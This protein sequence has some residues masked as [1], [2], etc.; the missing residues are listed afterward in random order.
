LASGTVEGIIQQLIQIFDEQGFGR[1][2]NIVSGTG[3]PAAYPL[4]KEYLKLISEE[5]ARAHVLP[6]KQNQYFCQR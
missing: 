5:Q 6:S 3:N 2:W 1:Y 4:V